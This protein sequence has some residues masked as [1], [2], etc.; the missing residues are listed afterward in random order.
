[1]AWLARAPDRRGNLLAIR[2]AQSK[3]A[4]CSY[5]VMKLQYNEWFILVTFD[6]TVHLNSFTSFLTLFYALFL[7]DFYMA[8][9]RVLELGGAPL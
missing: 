9:I 3:P 4:L 1:M 6:K 8:Y 7:T 2:P 5:E